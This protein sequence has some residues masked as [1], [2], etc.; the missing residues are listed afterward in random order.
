MYLW[1]TWAAKFDRIVLNVWYAPF[2]RRMFSKISP[3]ESNLLKFWTIGGILQNIL[4]WNMVCGAKDKEK[5]NEELD[6]RWTFRTIV[7]GERCIGQFLQSIPMR[8]MW[9]QTIAQLRTRTFKPGGI[10]SSMA[11]QCKTC[12]VTTSLVQPHLGSFDKRVR[13]VEFPEQTWLE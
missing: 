13:F 2:L 1:T 12:L 5:K 10:V 9:T 8:R 6:T 3:R 4:F 7:F 11:D